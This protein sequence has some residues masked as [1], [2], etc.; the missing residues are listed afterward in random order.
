VADRGTAWI[1]AAS[2]TLMLAEHVAG[3]ALRDAFFLSTFGVAALPTM[4]IVAAVTSIAVVPVM[5]RVLSKWGPA[6]VVTPA[7]AVSAALIAGSSLLA[8]SAPRA[9]A[10]TVYLHVAAINAVLISWFWSLINE[11]FDPRTARREMRRMVGGAA[12][13]GLLGGLVAERAAVHLGGR[14]MLLTL[15]AMH[16][17]CA[18][19][20]WR[21]ARGAGTPRA[22]HAA[23]AS[24][25][26]VLRASGYAR[27][28]ALLVALSTVAAA[29]V[30]YVFKAQAV[31]AYERGPALLR[32]FALFYAATGVLT[33]ALQTLL[34]QVSLEKLG[35]ARTVA[36]LPSAV[37]LGGFAAL[38]AP[39]LWTITTLRA[40]EAALHSSLYR[41]GYELFF[42]PM[43][44]GD[45]RAAKTVIDVGFDRLGDAVGGGLLKLILAFAG[46]AA[47]T[48]ALGAAIGVSVV[49]ALLALQLQRGY[50]RALERSLRDRADE[51][52]LDEVHDS[53]VLSVL[54]SIEARPVPAAPPA[55]PPPEPGPRLARPADPLLERIAALRSREPDR[56]RRALADGPLSPALVAHAVPLLAWDEV[57]THAIAALARVADATAGQLTDALLSPDEEFAVRRRMPRVLE[58]ASSPR[59][60]EGL[61][62]GLADARFEVRYRCGQALARIHARAPDSPLDRERIFGCVLAEARIDRGVWESQRLLDEDTEDAEPFVDE[63]LRDRA[64]R[65]L[66]HVFTLLSLAFPRK[67]LVLAF[68]GLHT[69]DEHLRGTALEYLEGV[70]PADVRAALWPYLEDRRGARPPRPREA[71][72]QELLVSNKSIQLNLEEA[73][74]RIRGRGA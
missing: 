45:K 47:A 54:R 50:V 27:K 41:S 59:V 5:A 15:A 1:A 49:V 24:G 34:S 2:A 22:R 14:A 43:A 66:E 18:V 23:P 36:A 13:G 9:A 21:L 72:L 30:D 57:A 16:A 42:T 29:M 33:F 35:I 64:S 61:L 67:P 73:R 25:L 63:L 11:R 10:V 31:A 69:S 60:V 71:V 68:R 48:V 70:L 51:V 44:P 4:F 32:F 7:F 46:T 38:L 39:G 55:E 74:R 40:A 28:L 26:A 6:R 62:A 17:G 53:N 3:K 65:S 58:L 12:L 56:V 52:S 19:A 8:T 20:T 37:A